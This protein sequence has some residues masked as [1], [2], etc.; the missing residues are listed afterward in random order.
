MKKLLALFLILMMC[1]SFSACKDKGDDANADAGTPIASEMNDDEL[2]QEIR[3]LIERNLDCYFIFN[4]APLKHTTQQNSD[5]Y[6]GTD[7]SFLESYADLENL[8]RSTYS[9]SEA[10]ELLNFPSADKPLY[11]NSNGLIFVN[12][13]VITPVKYNILWEDSYTINF[14]ERTDDE[15]SFTLKTVDIDG[16]EYTTEGSA[17]IENN[18]WLL[19]DLVY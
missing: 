2:E 7:G 17:V 18:S 1:L 3:F 11:K 12:P 4:V 16:K 9:K 13:D 10:D 15:C 5:G 14:T 8:V 6:Y 19:T